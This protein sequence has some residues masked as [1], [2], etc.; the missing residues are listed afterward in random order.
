MRQNGGKF[1]I[2]NWYSHSLDGW[3][4][5]HSG[6]F[7]SFVNRYDDTTIEDIRKIDFELFQLA[8]RSGWASSSLTRGVYLVT[9]TDRGDF[10]RI[11]DRNGPDTMADCRFLEWPIDRSKYRSENLRFIWIWGRSYQR[12]FS[13]GGARKCLLRCANV[14]GL[15]PVKWATSPLSNITWR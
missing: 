2:W 14:G 6:H 5:W 3:H 12:M 11:G 15:E 10:F 7:P 1:D 13:A 4:A 9:V 8:L